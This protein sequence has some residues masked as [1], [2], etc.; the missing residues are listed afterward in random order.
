[1]IVLNLIIF[2]IVLTLIVTVHEL[3]HFYFAKKAD[4]LCHEFSIG[5][6][7]KVVQKKKGETKYSFRAIPLGGYVAM[8]GEVEDGGSLIKG[9]TIGLKLDDETKL[10]KGILDGSLEAEVKGE[11]VDFDLYGKNMAP[12]FI[13]LKIDEEVIRY[14]VLRNAVYV[15]KNNEEVYIEPEERSYSGKTLWERFLVV[16]AGPM[17]N[18]ILAFLIYFALAFFVKAPVR[19]SNMLGEINKNGY[20]HEAGIKTGD[21]ITHVNGITVNSFNE[22]VMTITSANSNK[23]TVTIDGVDKELKLNVYIQSAGITN[24]N[25]AASDFNK[26]IIGS[27][28]GRAGG[29]LKAGDL[30]KSINGTVITSWNDIIVYFKTNESVVDYKFIVERDG[31]EVTAEYKGLSKETLLEL[32]ASESVAFDGGFLYSTKFEFKYFLKYPFVKFGQDFTSM[33]KTLKLLVKPKSDVGVGDLS[34]FV[35]IFSMVSN[36]AKNGFKSL[37]AFTAFISINIGLLN[38]LPIP[39]LDGGRLVFIAYEGITRKKVNKKVEG[40]LITVTFFLLLGMIVFVTYKDILRF[41]QGVF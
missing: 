39:A 38:L 21:V 24:Q 25:L 30:I 28:G 34:G 22:I 3:G 37:L 32:G 9:S 15:L 29:H 16:I 10:V 17:M 14:E 27:I 41:I 6:G 26:P 7:P 20:A 12:L 18:F 1:M 4:I 13:D 2:F 31:K 8:A 11:V 40:I 5:M 36:S 35:G 23:V 33:G 19:D